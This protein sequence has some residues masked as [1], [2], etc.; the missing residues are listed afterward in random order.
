MVARV[1]L[2]ERAR[3]MHPRRGGECH[4]PAF[5]WGLPRRHRVLLPARNRRG[6][7]SDR[8]RHV[9][10]VQDARRSSITGPSRFARPISTR[11][12]SR[13]AHIDHS[14]LMPKLVKAGFAR[15][16]LRDARHGRSVLD[17]AAG[18]RLHP[19]NGG[20]AAQPPQRAAAGRRDRRADLHRRGR[21]R[22]AS[23]SSGPCLTATGWT[24]PRLPRALLERRASARLRLR[25][26]WR[27]RAAGDR[28]DA[29][30][31]L[32]RR[33]PGSQAASARSGRAARSRLRGLRIHLRRHGPAGSSTDAAGA[34]CC[35]TRSARRCKRAARC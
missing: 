18:L 32:R 15:P 11:C 9:P 16:D 3:G 8:L 22:R 10:G 13:H 4:A 21:D 2:N 34:S 19:G 23:R 24:S 33:R 5:S 29:P 17:H 20:R 26:R 31:V 25:S 12:A 28:A 35:A 30:S 1:G 14:G 6:Q 27:S 7:G